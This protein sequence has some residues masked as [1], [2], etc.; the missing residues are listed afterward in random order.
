MFCLHVCLCMHYVSGI[1]EGQRRTLDFESLVLEL[2]IA[3]S[4]RVG[5]GNRASRFSVRAITTLNCQAISS[6]SFTL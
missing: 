5:A 1:L 2:W 3:V 4:H 6:P